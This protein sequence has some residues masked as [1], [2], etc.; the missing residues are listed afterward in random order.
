MASE[1]A[2]DDYLA[3]RIAI[4]SGLFS[5][6]GA[7]LAWLIWLSSQV[8]LGELATAVACGVLVGLLVHWAKHYLHV[9]KSECSDSH[10]NAEASHAESPG[11]MALVFAAGFGF[12]GLACEHLV[13]DLAA[14]F[15][16]PL[17]ASLATLL[18]AGVILGLV[19]H[20]GNTGERKLTDIIF[21]GALSGLAIA[22]VTGLIWYLGWGVVPFGGLAAWWILVSI[23]MQ[24]FVPRE[25]GSARVYQPI[26][27]TLVA[28]L[29]VIGFSLLPAR[30]ALYTTSG[31]FGTGLVFARTLAFQVL[32]SPGLPAKFWLEAMDSAKS[33][34]ESEA[35]A[36][37]PPSSIPEALRLPQTSTSELPT[38]SLRTSLPNRDP[39]LE[40]ERIDEMRQLAPPAH[41]L[42]HSLDLA[43]KL[44]PDNRDYGITV[45]S[46]N[47][48]TS[49]FRLGLKSPLVCSWLILL[50]FSAAL[51]MTPLIEAELRPSDYPSS[52]TF[53]KD[54]RI[55]IFL[56]LAVAAACIVARMSA[57]PD[58]KLVGARGHFHG[59]SA[60][61]FDREVVLARLT[62][63]PF[64]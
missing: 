16:Q 64:E 52:A 53:K 10:A 18:P 30:W 37:K 19:W 5:S 20:F 43:T 60:L 50:L 47:H 14:R 2:S 49:E 25:P 11:R 51:G 28:M 45:D 55:G 23:G 15:L 29:M 46:W 41:N 6:L 59:S 61:V 22:L 26:A 63:N 36:A 1:L 33:A 48:V 12:L 17:L 4:G 3:F 38:T 9:A 27:G 57:R 42:A 7:S 21:K 40:S 39:I 58:G 31:P 34:R 56:L 44:Q 54:V 32:E 24:C 62:D 8:P 13:A 35:P